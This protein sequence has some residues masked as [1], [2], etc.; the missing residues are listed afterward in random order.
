MAHSDFRESNRVCVLGNIPIEGITVNGRKRNRTCDKEGGQEDNSSVQKVRA[1]F[2]VVCDQV[3][4]K[5]SLAHFGQ[6]CSVHT[7]I[8]H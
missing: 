7:I 2:N 3:G 5:V 6:E 1:G 8:T 4:E